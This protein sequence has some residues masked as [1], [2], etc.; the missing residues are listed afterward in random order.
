MPHDAHGSAD[1]R[2][3]IRALLRVHQVR[4][5]TDEPVDDAAVDAV[6]DVGRWTGSAK[7]AQPWRFI[8][9]RD[10]AALRHLAEVG[11]PQTRSL[12][13]AAAAI[14]ITIPAETGRTEILHAYDEGRAA[15]RMLDAAYLVGLAASIA[16]VR[17]DV[18][19]AVGELLGLP[20]DRMARTIVALGRPT[21]EASR[22]TAAPGTA[23][24]PRDQVVFEG[25]WQE[26]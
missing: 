22:P 11:A 21:A 4:E 2:D 8:V 17:G 1:P 19:Q 15:E 6:A 3:R 14:V 20:E 25:R 5:F 12:A 16:W 23:R 26:R 10:R 24:L 9:I 7:N 13:T 18:R